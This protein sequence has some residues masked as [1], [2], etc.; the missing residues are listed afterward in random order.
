MRTIIYDETLEITR[1]AHQLL[2]SRGVH[3]TFAGSRQELALAFA[4]GEP[5]ALLIVN[6]DG[7]LTS[8]ELAEE[9][10]RARYEG[11]ALV[12]VDRV[13]TP[14]ASFLTQLPRAECLVHPSSPAALED[15][16]KRVVS[17]T[18]EALPRAVPQGAPPLPTFHGMVGQSKAMQD[19]FCRIKK[20]ALGDANVCI[21]GE[22]GTGKELIA[23]AI[24]YSSSRRDRPLITLDCAAV[25]EGLMESHLFGHVKGAFTSAVD[26]REGVFS[27]AHTGTLFIDELCELS[28]PLQAKLLRVV[29]SREFLKVGGT[30]PIHT[31]VRLIMATNQDPKRAVERGTFREDLYY[32]VAVVMIKVPP[33]RERKDDVPLLVE[34]FLRKFSA[35]YSKRIRSVTP[36][37]MDRMMALLWP[38]NVRQLENF[39]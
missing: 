24:H 15:L 31:D 2:P 9:L 22:S 16:L 23:R 4:A 36:S 39:L 25:P 17:E 34:H 35:V 29:Q 30:K 26:H 1:R 11:R 28:L 5:P 8:W 21:Y 33:L 38:G 6:L 27:L 37:V 18:A 12:L 10:R 3:V 7:D 32:R 14:G 19:I 20:V 13:H